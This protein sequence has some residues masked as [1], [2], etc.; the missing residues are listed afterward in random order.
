MYIQNVEI[1]IFE[2]YKT[3]GN[4]K[5]QKATY[6]TFKYGAIMDLDIL[7]DLI[8]IFERIDGESGH[9]MLVKFKTLE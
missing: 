3:K 4:T 5:M 1:E 8:K 6:G 9:E 7:T 2:Q